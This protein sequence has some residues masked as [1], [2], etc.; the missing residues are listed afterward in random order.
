MDK[1]VQNLS[2]Q[3]NLLINASKYANY[4]KNFRLTVLYLYNVTFLISFICFK[5]QKYK[6]THSH[7]IFQ[8][9]IIYIKMTLQINVNMLYVYIILNHRLT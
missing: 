7:G 1:K 6:V 5:I 8:L 4:L 3:F 2:K 9:L